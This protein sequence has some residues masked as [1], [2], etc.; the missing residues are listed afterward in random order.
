M[1]LQE[2][3]NDTRTFLPPQPISLASQASLSCIL[4]DKL[5]QF[6]LS[7]LRSD[8]G[9]KNEAA[10]IVFNF[11]QQFTVNDKGSITNTYVYSN[12]T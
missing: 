4:Y 6:D 8:T 1:I 7:D 2:E 5:L 9:Y 12:G 3:S 11:C 10:G